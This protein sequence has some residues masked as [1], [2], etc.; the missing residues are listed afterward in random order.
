MS[1]RW[2]LVFSGPPGPVGGDGRVVDKQYNAVV[3]QERSMTA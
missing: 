3:K 1:Q 2:G